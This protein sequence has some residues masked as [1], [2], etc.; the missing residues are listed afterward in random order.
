[1]ILNQSFIEMILDGVGHNWINKDVI[2]F[3]NA[4]SNRV[5]D[6]WNTAKTAPWGLTKPLGQVTWLT[7]TAAPTVTTTNS[8]ITTTTT[9]STDDPDSVT[10][11]VS[12]VA[13]L[14]LGYSQT[15]SLEILTS[16]VIDSLSD[17][18]FLLPFEY[19]QEG[20]EEEL[21]NATNNTLPVCARSVRISTPPTLPPSADAFI[22]QDD[23]NIIII[24]V[25]ITALSLTMA[26]GYII[27]LSRKEEQEELSM[28]SESYTEEALAMM[29]FQLEIE[30]LDDY[31]DDDNYEA[32]LG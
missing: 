5:R 22:A 2:S 28:E 20:Y 30:D 27:Y 3:Q 26:G 11:N 19:D 4:T 32:S 18:L 17:Q 12:V 14:Q 29:G 21:R 24:T 16:W 15:I 13:P 9:A 7:I 23:K 10:N 31:D 1:M 25:V 8:T 6:F